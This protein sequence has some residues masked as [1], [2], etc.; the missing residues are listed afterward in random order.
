MGM[1]MNKCCCGGTCLI[2]KDE[3]D[4][5]NDTTLGSGWTELVGDWY[6]NVAS[7]ACIDAVVG[8]MALAKFN[9][10][11]PSSFDPSKPESMVVSVEILDEVAG[12]KYALLVN[13]LD[14]DNYNIAIYTAPI[15][16]TSTPGNIELGKVSGGTYTSYVD[17]D[18]DSVTIA[19]RRLF[20]ALIAEGEFCAFVD[21]SINSHVEEPSPEIF[22]DGWY[23]GMGGDH[24]SDSLPPPA[25]FYQRSRFDNFQFFHHLATKAGCRYCLCRCGPTYIP[26]VLKATATGYGTMTGLTGCEI[27][28]T[29]NRTD[30]Y[31]SGSG[32]CCSSTFLLKFDCVNS[33]NPEDFVL[34][35]LDGSQCID[36]DP[37]TP[38]LDHGQKYA[39]AEYST[40]EPFY[41]R[42]GLFL[43]SSG[44]LS[45]PC[46]PPLSGSGSYMWE[47]AP[48]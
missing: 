13:Y 41:L 46:R 24:R 32:T 38:G 3:F 20:T 12:A 26:Q 11:H 17:L 33:D 30:G 23:C 8:T 15:A 4:R 39:S 40:C 2:A 5:P 7:E 27:I 44:D 29:W 21:F 1:N 37:D 45:C 35:V 34:S 28:L 36:S 16:A 18:I 25:M 14:S 48:P 43:V 31:W 19:S 6:I 10:I 22:M 9:T 42:F 47:L